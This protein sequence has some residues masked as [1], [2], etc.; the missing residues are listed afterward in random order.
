MI[1]RAPALV[2]GVFAGL[3]ASAVLAADTPPRLSLPVDC[4]PGQSCF[5]Q[6]HVDTDPG[7]DARDFT[8]GPLSYDGHRGTDF[9]VATLADMRAGVR[10][11]A[12][13]PGRVAAV[14]DGM[15]DDGGRGPNLEAKC[16]NGVRIAHGGRWMTL[17][18]HLR[19]G[20]IR[21]ETGQRITAGTVLGEIGI[22]GRAD[23]PHLHFDLRH[24]GR[25]IDPYTGRAMGAGCGRVAKSYWHEA[26][27]RRLAYRASGLLGMAI[28]ATRPDRGRIRDGGQ[29]Q[30]A[31]LAGPRELYLW[32]EL[33]GLRTGDI[34]EMRLLTRNGELLAEE[35][36]DPAM[37]NR[38]A[39]FRY[40]GARRKG[41]G[42]WPP[43]RY[44][45]EYRLLRPDPTHPTPRVVV[46]RDVELRL[47]GE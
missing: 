41:G 25:S 13:A 9:R 18:C 47:L 27:A 20:S 29:R 23:F 36:F 12:A 24:R 45:G 8:C 42:G 7:P 26:T 46:A 32:T 6:N 31:L 19:K 1:A 37:R 43:G 21:V 35:R 22:S 3:A 15:A 16:G 34:E 44:R 28:T 38:A 4:E 11:L 2:W 14:R 17:Y 33:F 5:V 39:Q 30:E 10:V 40:I